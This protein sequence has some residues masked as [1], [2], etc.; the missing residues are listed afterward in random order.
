MSFSNRFQQWFW[1]RSVFSM[2]LITVI[3]CTCVLVVVAVATLQRVADEHPRRYLSRV[4]FQHVAEMQVTGSLQS[5]VIDGVQIILM[6]R[7]EAEGSEYRSLLDAAEADSDGIAI[8]SLHDHYIAGMLRGDTFVVLPEFGEEISTRALVLLGILFLSTAA[9]ITGIFFLIRAMTAPFGII[10]RGIEQV[11]SGD[12]THEIPTNA[13]YGEFRAL[14]QSFN[15][16]VE[17]VHRTHE[18]RRQMLLA[19]PHELFAPLSRLKVRKDLIKDTDLRDNVARDIVVLEEILNAILATE[20]KQIGSQE[21]EVLSIG[22]V[23]DE[24]TL[25]FIQDGA[26]FAIDVHPSTETIQTHRFIVSVVLKNFISNAVR[27]GLGKQIDIDLRPT[28]DNGEVAISVRDHGIG[29]EKHEIPYMTEPFWRADKARHRESGG[30]GLG[31]YICQV[32]VESLGGRLEI[33]SELNDGTTATAILPN[34]IV[35]TK[36]SAGL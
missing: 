9:T 30:F 7:G 28:G 25:P 20:R 2:L 27:Y 11:E 12:F 4:L 17:Q 15:K 8:R 36:G 33:D 29:V 19:I 1:G 10:S 24:A 18:S 6:D 23:I 34:A 26:E 14:A 35:N 13:T 16:M 21:T 22:A 3:A 32:M 5:H 31:L